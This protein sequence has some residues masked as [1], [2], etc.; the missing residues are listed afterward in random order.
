V[1]VDA[2]GAEHPLVSNLIRH[3]TFGDDPHVWA[4]ALFDEFVELGY[5]LS[6]PSFVRQLREGGLRPHC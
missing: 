5:A 2:A 3:S 6:Y 1:I 4:S